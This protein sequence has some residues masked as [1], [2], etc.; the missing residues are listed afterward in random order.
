MMDWSDRHCRYFWRQLTRSAR[1]YTEMVTTAALIHGPRRELLA[2]DAAEQPL[3]LQLGGSDPGELA[4]CAVYAQQRGFAEVNL[5][6]GCPSDRVQNGRFGACLMAEPD[7]VAE[8][9]GAMRAACD[10]PVTV[11]HRIG[12][13]DQDSAQA[14]TDFVGTVAAAGC[15]TFIVHARKAWLQGLSPKQN[16][17]IPPLDYPL[18]YRLKRQFPDLNIVINGAV[19]DLAQAQEHLH[20]V[21]G[22]M[23]GRAAYQNPWLLARAD[24]TLFGHAD[25]MTERTRVLATMRAYI[26]H[27]LS[28]GARLN[29]ITRH[30]LGLF[31]G[32]P[33]GRVYRRHL[34][35]HA[36]RPG[37]GLEVLESAFALQQQA[38][39][40]VVERATERAVER[41]A[42]SVVG[43]EAET[44]SGRTGAT[45]TANGTAEN[46]NRSTDRL[47]ARPHTRERA[48]EQARLSVAT[49]S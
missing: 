44:G 34:S 31:Q 30:M 21:D 18:V 39:A 40:R 48:R 25:P 46:G 28:R 29:H 4:Q 5:N 12:I 10:I 8:C 42:E 7:R 14:L 26:E 2:F 47:P 38:E 32:R 36:H 16:R 35:Q 9:V 20:R 6:C 27:E 13:D 41:A 15:E 43:A 11:K 24:S 22:V 17:D 37:A 23:L 45:V 1:L 33:G 3:A 19:A 49:D